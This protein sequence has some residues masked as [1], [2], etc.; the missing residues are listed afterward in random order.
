MPIDQIR[1]NLNVGVTLTRYI[2]NQVDITI[3]NNL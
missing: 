1:H 2:I 3:N